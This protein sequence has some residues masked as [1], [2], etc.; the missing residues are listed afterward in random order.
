VIKCKTK[1]LIHFNFK[2]KY[3]E[4]FYQANGINTKLHCKKTSGIY[5]LFFSVQ[6]PW[7]DQIAIVLRGVLIEKDKENA[8]L[9]R[10][11]IIRYF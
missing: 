6:L 3:Q 8:R 10:R 2:E 1:N 4:I 5:I 7:P 9:M 11:Q